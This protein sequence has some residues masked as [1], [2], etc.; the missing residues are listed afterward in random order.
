MRYITGVENV[1]NMDIDCDITK[2]GFSTCGITL[3]MVWVTSV[4]NIITNSNIC[5]RGKDEL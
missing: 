1:T 5:L 4:Y 2:F 3:G